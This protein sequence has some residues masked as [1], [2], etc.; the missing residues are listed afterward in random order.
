MTRWQRFRLLPW[1]ATRAPVLGLALAIAGA[2]GCDAIGPGAG[3]ER[4]LE[5]IDVS[6]VEV[7]DGDSIRVGDREIRILGYDA[8]E[9]SAPWFRGDQEP[10]ASRAATALE[11]ALR[12][13][14]RVTYRRIAEEDKYGRVLAQVY[15]DGV[16][17]GVP[18][19][20]EGL[21]YE[22]VS[23]YGHQGLEEDAERLLKAAARGPDPAFLNPHSWR[24]THSVEA[25][26]D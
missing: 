8:P 3:G 16:P 15:V 2:V 6:R 26:E 12:R 22:T 25:R 11:Q 9:L 17:V 14:E 19:L 18:L 21:A 4:P 23:R 24:R 20:E 5:P 13:A 10:W 7:L 1:I